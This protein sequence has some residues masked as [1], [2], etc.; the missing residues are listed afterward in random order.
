VDARQLIVFDID[1]DEYGI[2]IS[3]ISSIER[4]PEIF[5]VPE[6]A[7]YVEGLINLRGKV[8]TVINLRKRL[9]K[10]VREFD[11][12]TKVVMVYSGDSIIGIIID[13]VNRMIKLEEGNYEIHPNK[14]AGP[15]KE[16]VEGIIV[17]GDYKVKLLN[18]EKLTAL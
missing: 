18:V 8:H 7:D 11:E 16:F 10:P 9:K 2:D 5:R 17:S 14:K 1:S 3:K 15:D 4:L 6:A 13:N 12:E